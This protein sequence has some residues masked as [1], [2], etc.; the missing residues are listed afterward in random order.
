MPAYLPID[1]TR[2]E[3]TVVLRDNLFMSQPD[4]ADYYEWRDS[5]VMDEAHWYGYVVKFVQFRVP[6]V[7]ID[8][9]LC[10]TRTLC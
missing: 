4:L 5:R 2:W 6:S 1:A 3:D 10:Y 9:V 7:E 8:I